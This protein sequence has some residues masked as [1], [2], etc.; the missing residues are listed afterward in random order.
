MTDAS[1]VLGYIDPA[2]FAGGAVPLDP[3]LARTVILE[4]VAAPLGLSLEQ[5]ALGIHRVVNAQMAEGIRLVS[6]K[7]GTDPRRFTLVALG[8]GGALHA[9]ELAD[10][11]GITQVA[12]PL[13]PG[14]LSAIGLLAAPVEHEVSKGFY[15][16]V[17]ETEVGE[18]GLAFEELDRTCA[19]LM[20]DEHDAASITVSHFA[21]MCYVGQSYN[22]EIPVGP[23]DR[24]TLPRLYEEF[25]AMHDQVYGHS[26]A[27]PARIVN[28]RTVH[29]AAASAGFVQP[30]YRPSGGTARK[31]TRSVVLAGGDRAEAIVWD[32][33]ALQP[34]RM[35]A[36]PAIIEQTDTT[37]VFGPQ[38]QAE[39]RP[40]GSLILG[41]NRA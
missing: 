9:T 29:R 35:I 27:N 11:L 14:V 23:L 10:E 25:L 3:A 30:P 20:A 34:G 38:W 39:V 31:G 16:T 18:I 1:V 13:H 6:V 28:L 4:R 26:T 22:L 36:G 40:C 24:G 32:R 33:M 41:R 8:G 5:A 19:Q 37:T 21:D 17:A 12:V 7:R 2:F 15:R